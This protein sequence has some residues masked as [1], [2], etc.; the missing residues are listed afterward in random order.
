MRREYR[1]PGFECERQV[2]GKWPRPFRDFFAAPGP[3]ARIA[4][5]TDLACLKNTLL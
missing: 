1:Y 2:P 3:A 5:A 4:I